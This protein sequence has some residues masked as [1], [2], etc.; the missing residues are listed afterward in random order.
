MSSLARHVPNPTTKS[1]SN[2]NLFIVECPHSL[3]TIPCATSYYILTQRPLIH[4]PLYIWHTIAS[5][6]SFLLGKTRSFTCTWTHTDPA[7]PSVKPKWTFESLQFFQ[8]DFTRLIDPYT[9]YF[10]STRRDRY[11]NQPYSHPVPEK[12]P[13][14]PLEGISK[15]V[16]PPLS[17]RPSVTRISRPSPPSL[18]RPPCKF[19]ILFPFTPAL[20]ATTLPSLPTQ[21]NC[22]PY[23][24]TT[25]RNRKFCSSVESLLFR[26]LQIKGRQE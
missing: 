8:P 24:Q 11:H 20:P 4:R 5:S 22:D 10:R 17:T 19:Q 23:R 1:L 26:N 15:V 9:P 2:H 25:S 21:H 13:A 6:H 3:T 7:H 18:S 12:V 16:L 14:Q